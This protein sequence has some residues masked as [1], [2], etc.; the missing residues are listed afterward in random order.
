MDLRYK[1]EVT[2]GTLVIV[3]IVLFIVGTMWLSGRSIA[4]DNDEFWIQFP[5]GAGL[6]RAARR[7]GS[8]A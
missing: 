8:P 6:K 4:A 1:R 7:C 2:V 3:A 5:N